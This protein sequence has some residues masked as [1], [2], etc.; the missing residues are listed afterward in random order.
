MT[1]TTDKTDE[2]IDNGEQKKTL[3]LAR[4][5]EARPLVERDQVR[6]RFA[7]GRSKTVEVEVRK[8]RATTHDRSKDDPM[9]AA[10]A[11]RGLTG[12]EFDQRMRVLRESMIRQ[13]EEDV[14]KKIHDEEVA[15][16]EIIQKKLQAERALAEA[17]EAEAAT[18]ANSTVTVPAEQKTAATLSALGEETHKPTA[19]VR[20]PYESRDKS[21]GYKGTNPRTPQISTPHVY[22]KEKPSQ[23][24]YDSNRPG[25]DRPAA[26]RT[27]T[28]ARPNDRAGDRTGQTSSR[29]PFQSRNVDLKKKPISRDDIQ[30]IIFRAEGYA[31]KPRPGAPVGSKAGVV[32]QVPLTIDPILEK[33]RGEHRTPIAKPRRKEDEDDAANAALANKL[34]PKKALVKTRTGQT[35]EAPRKLNRNVLTRVLDGDT[36]SRGRSLASVK[37]ARQ[38]HFK[39]HHNEQAEATKIV[40]DVIIPESMTVGELA[41]R[42][43]VRGADVVK[44]LMNLG[45]MVTINQVIDA[46]TAELVCGEF[47]HT[48]KR[49]ADS[50]I[51]IGLGGTYDDLDK[52]LLPRAPVVTVMG[53]VDHGKTS[54]LDALRETDVVSGE[55]G[56][57]TQHIG[58]YQ[59]TMQSGKKITFIDTPGHAA[60]SEMR[61]RGANATDI[62]I[63]VVAAD[64]GI[65][66]QTI[67]A[68]NHAKAANVPIVVAINK[69]DK[70]DANSSRVRQ[71][72][73]QHGIL[74]E[75][76]GGEV[77]AVDVSAKKRMNLEK[78]EEIILLQAE[79]LEL[80]ANPNRSAHGI[81]IEAEID[82]GRG[83]LA[84]VLVQRGTLK[85]GDIFVAGQEW[86]RVKALVN[87]RAK[88]I[89]EASPSM[90][91]EVLGFNGVPAAGDE[92]FVVESEQR[93]REIAEYRQRRQREKQSIVKTKGGMEN[94]MSRIANGEIREMPIVIKADVQGSLEAIIASV[95]KLGNEEV[96]TRVL[97]GAVGG[98]NESDVTLARASGGLIVGFNVRANP[99]AR[100]LARRDGVEIRYYSIIYDV[101][102]EVRGLMSGL[103][104]PTLREKHQGMAEI[105]SV[106]S[107]SKVAGKVAGCYITEGTIKRGAKVRLLRDNVVIHEG[108]LKSLKRFKDEVKEVK[109]QFECGMVFENFH[110]IR[111]GDVVECFEIES[112]ARQ[113]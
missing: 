53:H 32:A 2:K 44:S 79:I 60:F 15:K 81:I 59:V 86:G 36:E 106:F 89:S 22:S 94:I 111:E 39:Q 46:D 5:T 78:L 21:S 34:D 73:L 93:A 100:D 87:D 61:A 31:P 68:I 101:I 113:L 88:K 69:M 38:K 103:L 6:Q 13:N 71:E 33:N 62:V 51:E 99:Q 75:E 76:F 95:A 40:R 8:K 64:D 108:D 3:T 56:G 112:I 12:N 30:P 14:K 20:P 104:A 70:P 50:D 82:K 72:L 4:K 109:E 43:A 97:H 17:R 23:I 84:T 96:S 83:T 35:Q 91:V 74:L 42:M 58:A 47:G 45:M 16:E 55:A 92:F 11:S 77:M 102:D 107:I 85:G 19:E 7:H 28:S 37:R 29:P 90:P 10:A 25:T 54:L 66:E 48:P 63:L 80:K 52:D 67:E 24:R 57:I 65:M 98:I 27:S 18:L 1:G 105:R 110:D 26:D 41:N 49:V 9:A